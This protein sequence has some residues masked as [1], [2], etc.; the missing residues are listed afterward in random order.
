MSSETS[1]PAPAVSLS[2]LAGAAERRV[3]ET[4]RQKSTAQITS[5]YE[6][7]QK[8]R[9]LIDPGIIRPNSETQAHRSIKVTSL[10]RD[11]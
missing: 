2:A 9:R 8:F 3:L 5:E 7:R 10:Y 6:K 1:R 11:L 4:A